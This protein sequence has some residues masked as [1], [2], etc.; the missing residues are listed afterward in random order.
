V[1]QSTAIV[2]DAIM[3]T[4]LKSLEGKSL[5]QIRS[6]GD[7]DEQRVNELRP[8]IQAE[9]I[10]GRTYP[11][12]DPGG[13]YAQHVVAAATVEALSSGANID[14]IT[15][16]TQRAL[17]AMNRSNPSWTLHLPKRSTSIKTPVFSEK[18]KHIPTKT[19]V[20]MGGASGLQQ[21]VEGKMRGHPSVLRD[22]S[23]PV[24]MHRR[25]RR[26]RV[27][28]PPRVPQTQRFSSNSQGRGFR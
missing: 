1:K 8:L 18:K 27:A 2:A 16:G 24:K 10:K 20:H 25:S 9:W 19:I 3:N 14:K 5:A 12:V 21:P 22:E 11:K 13:Y 6:W 4:P 7:L 28:P 15:L 17:R 26:S 23:T